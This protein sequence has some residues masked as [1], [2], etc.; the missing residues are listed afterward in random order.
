MA[1]QNINVGTRDAKDGESL[2][3][4]FTKV[5]ANFT[6]LY[7]SGSNSTI[8]VRD[9]SDFGVIDSTKIY[10]IDGFI[11]M[12]STTIQVPSS[13]INIQGYSTNISGLFSSAS[14]YT[15]FQ[16]SGAGN[17]FIV[18]CDLSVSGVNSKVLDLSNGGTAA[19]EIV[20][21]NFTNCTNIGEINGYR[22]GLE[23]NTS[24]FGGN[25]RLT[26]S[27]A[28]TG[29]YFISTSIVRGINSAS[30]FLFN[31]GTGF[32]MQSRFRTNQNIDLPLGVGL[33]DF[34]DANFP[35]SSTLQLIDMI[36][37][38]NGVLD[39][40]DTGYT[41]NITADNLSCRWKGN[42][43]L[44][45]TFEGGAV[46]N[47]AEAAT[48]VSATSTFYDLNGTWDTSELVHFDSPANGQ[49]RNLGDT[50][51]AFTVQG[52]FVLES[53]AN[54]IVELKVVVFRSSTST[55]VD[56]QSIRRPIANSLG[57]DDVAY[58]VVNSNITLNQNDYV[59][60]QVANNTSTANII[61]K[62]D[63]Y[64]KVDAK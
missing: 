21:V 42:T 26:L 16:G 7:S 20:N 9:A 61:A 40:E 54:D 49:L 57:G 6:D 53:G 50:P 14:T 18:D 59:K 4:A 22:Q 25:P 24:R 34:S 23:I 1:Q 52:Q 5:E 45:N 47:S 51:T 35:N 46:N 37:T 17:V 43:G 41:P 63:S 56:G 30:Y 15:M 29:G 44:P 28:W 8:L 2:F 11:D 38:R 3:D 19:F 60:I 33:L 31:A 10:V 12:G 13:G 58:Y 32:T 64:F 27:G 39:S 48:V 55:F 62:D 36:V